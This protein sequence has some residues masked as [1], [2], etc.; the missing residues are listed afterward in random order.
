MLG[1]AVITSDI[2]PLNRTEHAYAAVEGLAGSMIQPYLVR[3]NAPV[4]E[5]QAR[6]VL[7][8]LV[9]AY[10][11]LRAIIEPGLRLYHFRILPDDHVV[12]Q[13]FEL[14]FL[15]EPYIDIDDPRALLRWQHRFLHEVL[16]LERGLGIRIR[17]VPHAT[18]AALM[19][20]VP[21]IFGDGMTMLH[22]V[23]QIVRG[24]NGQPIEPMPI[25]APAMIGAIAP[26]KWWE[27]PAKI[28]RSRQHKVAEA[29]L[30]KSLHVQQIP[31]RPQPNFSTT[32]LMHHV[33]PTSA[34]DM[35]KA[36]RKLRTSVSTLQVAAIAQTFL[37]QA[38]DDPKAAA[39]IR[40][41]VNLRRYFPRSAG[42]GPLWGNHV[43]AFLVI[44][45]GAR[46]S[47]PERVQSIEASMKEGQS[48]YARR[49]MCWTYLLDE[50][51]PLLGRT[52][53][54]HVGVLMKRKMSFPRISAHA[55]SLGEVSKLINPANVAI[56]VDQFLPAVSSIAPL[57][58]LIEMDGQLIMPMVWQ[59]CETSRDDIEDFMR[60]LDATYARM[61]AEA[62]A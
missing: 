44:E 27:W 43:G 17:F 59:E 25:E 13:L 61:V 11:K 54:A 1:M 7:R 60:R 24:L 48:R 42:H 8:E 62:L 41:S 15:S 31:A 38:P 4:D 23:N 39:V 26:N 57:P 20:G 55:T 32:G 30:I 28:W 51:T 40:I 33:V 47:L 35:R 18:R 14:A 49:E 34:L 56:R 9:T 22:L 52:L 50:L 29:R 45:Q 2:V 5:A 53:I 10:P 12:D 3:F 58:G 37:D 16:P 21:H 36:A 6:R 46:K 19:I